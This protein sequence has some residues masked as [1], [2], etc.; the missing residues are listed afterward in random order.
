MHIATQHVANV[1]IFNNKT[2]SLLLFLKKIQKQSPQELLRH[3]DIDKNDI[4]LCLFLSVY[5]FKN[6]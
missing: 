1:T 3:K 6:I 2:R 5:N 4:P